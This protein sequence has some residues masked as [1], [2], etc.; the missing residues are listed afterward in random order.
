MDGLSEIQRNLNDSLAAK[1]KH[2][3]QD[4]LG[5][6]YDINIQPHGTEELRRVRVVYY[7]DIGGQ[8][9]SL[10]TFPHVYPSQ[11]PRMAKE[12]RG[13][14]K[15]ENEVH[16]IGTP[17]LSKESRSYLRDEQIPFIDLA[18]GFYIALKLPQKEIVFDIDRDESHKAEEWLK[19][20]SPDLPGVSAGR[21]AV[22]R[23]LLINPAKAWGVRELARTT[24]MDPGTT[25]RYMRETVNAG[26]VERISRG[27]HRLADPGALL[28]YWASIAKRLRKRI[29]HRCSFHPNDYD[30]MRHK[31][32]EYVRSH[33]DTYHTLWSGAE[34]YGHYREQPMVALYCS[35]IE[36]T[37]KQLGASFAASSREANL[38]LLGA[39]DKALGLGAVEHDAERAVCWQQVYVDLMNAPHRGKSIAAMLREEMEGK[40][41]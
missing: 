21:V 28:D 31:I 14:E 2:Y 29:V 10:H 15:R 26:W 18:G 7:D 36:E 27:E 25:S 38:W 13:L 39:T 41:E 8:M 6:A 4:R 3:L 32:K 40:G 35:T 1:L 34:F 9:I 19:R 17:K 33:A 16:V 22:Y 5:S 20:K 37:R 12:L 23:A 11:L 30:E 24:G